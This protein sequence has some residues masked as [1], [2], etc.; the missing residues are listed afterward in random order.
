[1]HYTGMAAMH[2]SPGIQYVPSLVILSIV[3][4]VAAS[5]AAV[6]GLLSICASNHPV[7]GSSVWGRLS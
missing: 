5:G 1:M 2:M 3:I 7:S 6:Y 4:A